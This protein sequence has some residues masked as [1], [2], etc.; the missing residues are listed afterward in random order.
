MKLD[1]L[2]LSQ[3]DVAHIE[4]R[5]NPRLETD[6]GFSFAEKIAFC[7]RDMSSMVKIKNM[8]KG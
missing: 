5:E 8:E 1:D 2:H 3:L 7:T 4:L 6:E